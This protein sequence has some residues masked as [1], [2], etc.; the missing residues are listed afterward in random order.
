MLYDEQPV[1]FKASWN[2]RLR[3]TKG[4]YQVFARYGKDLVKGIV[5]RHSFQCYDMLMVIAP[6]TLLTLASLLFNGGCLLAGLASG[7]LAVAEC[8]ASGLGGCLLSVYFS[9][10]AFG[11][12]TLITEQKQIHCSKPRQILYLLMFPVFIFTYIPMAVVALRK[13]V[14][15]KHIPHSILCTAD[16]ICEKK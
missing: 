9:L 3:W 6:A 1:T 4:F 2:Q 12:V 16:Q 15:W 13:N 5:L 10:L 11:I 7:T 14:T 8:A